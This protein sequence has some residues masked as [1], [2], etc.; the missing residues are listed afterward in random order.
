M[1]E[2]PDFDGKHV[3]TRRGFVT[4][5]GFGVV[6]L[7][8]LWAAYGAAPTSL[9]FMSGAED[10]GMKGMGHGGEGGM[11]PDEFR[12]LTEAFIEANSLPDGSVKPTRRSMASMRPSAGTDRTEEEHGREP[13]A[14]EHAEAAEEHTEDEPIEVYLM[15][16]QWGYEPDVLR[17][18]RNV[19]YKFRMMALDTYHGASINFGV[20]SRIVRLQP[21]N[22][23]EQEIKFTK[24]GKYT[25]YCTVYCGLA[26][27]YMRGSLT[28]T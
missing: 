25:V 20:A 13:A 4:A 21:G 19:P 23:V 15:A 2:R 11:S 27:D 24:Q 7:Y 17:L 28:I 14:E 9:A 5:L 1:A 10:G 6:S 22:L 18:E 3:T 8:G 12:R 16:Y 26:H